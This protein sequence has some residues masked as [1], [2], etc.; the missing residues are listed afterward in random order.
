MKMKSASMQ[1]NY[2]WAK[3]KASIRS[4]RVKKKPA[5]F[6]Q[7]AFFSSHSVA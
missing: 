2:F 3:G 1:C 4:G 5:T 7:Q 6:P